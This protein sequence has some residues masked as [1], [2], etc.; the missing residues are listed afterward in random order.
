MQHKTMAELASRWLSRNA[1]ALT[2]GERRVLQS[3]IERKTVARDTTRPHKEAARLGDRVADAVARIGGSWNFIIGFLVFLAAWTAL[4]SL[5]LL[6]GAFDPYPY[7]FLNLI[8]SMLAAIQAPVIM[9]SQNRQAERDRIDAAH[10]YE[11]NLKAEIEIMALHEKLDE[12]RHSQIVGMCDD[13]AR[14]SSQV[15]RLD[16][17]L[18]LHLKNDKTRK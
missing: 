8:L 13:I 15:R 18:A 5:L 1:E 11:V 12:L 10:D 6:S 17:T 4:N 14:I 16:E 7:I 2:E 9:M 3:A